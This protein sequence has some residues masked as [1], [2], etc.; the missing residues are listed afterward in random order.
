MCTT[1]LSAA[2]A[3]ERATSAKK[4]HRRQSFAIVVISK[5]ISKRIAATQW[6]GLLRLH[7][8]FF[9][10]KRESWFMQAIL[11]LCYL[12]LPSWLLSEFIFLGNFPLVFVSLPS[13]YL[14]TYVQIKLSRN[15]MCHL[16]AMNRW[17]VSKGF[18]LVRKVPSVRLLFWVAIEIGSVVL[19]EKYVVSFIGLILLYCWSIVVSS[20]VLVGS[21]VAYGRTLGFKHYCCQGRSGSRKILVSGA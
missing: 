14:S 5:V 9:S 19:C 15:F 7:Y 17:Q 1:C 12:L 4:A 11:R 21:A 13:V 3:D 20:Y 16:H 18:Y 8:G 6:L 10:R 2:G